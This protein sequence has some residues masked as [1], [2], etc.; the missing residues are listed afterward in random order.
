MTNPPYT[1]FDNSSY[2]SHLVGREWKQA[3]PDVGARCQWPC[4]SADSTFPQTDRRLRRPTGH[5]PEDR[6]RGRPSSR[7]SH[8]RRTNARTDPPVGGQSGHPPSV[9]AVIDRSF[10]HRVIPHGPLS[11]AAFRCFQL[12]PDGPGAE[13][14]TYRSGTPVAPT[15]RKR[16]CR[17]STFRLPPGC[18]ILP[19]SFR[20]K[21][22]V[23]GRYCLVTQSSILTSLPLL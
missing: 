18:A 23:D 10:Q 16:R 22:A 11:S 7:P 8:R 5:S 12:R 2:S 17:A 19:A 1:R 6:P 20:Q 4:A 3:S 21:I 15:S 14:P 13:M 9:E